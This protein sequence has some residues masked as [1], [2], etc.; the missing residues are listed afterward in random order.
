LTE[1]FRFNRALSRAPSPSVVDGL[2]AVDVGAPDFPGVVREHA[3][4]VRALEDAGV[5]VEVLPALNAFPDS[6]FV[7]DTALVFTGAAILLRPG[8]ASRFGEAAEMAP[9]LERSF[10]RVLRLTQGSVDGGDVLTTSRGVFIGR[11]A[12]TTA[13]GARALG[14]L[15]E[16]IGLHGIVVATP[17]D[18][19]H[20]KSDC[21]LLDDETIL[22]TRR[23]AAAGVFDGFR[24]ALV[25]DGE[26]AAANALR[27]ND[28]VLI[29]DGY[30]R[31]A[32]LLAKS[33]DV[34]ALPTREVAK[35]DAGL[36]CMSLRWRA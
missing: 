3:A 31:T 29:S 32:D 27:V 7:E 26:E 34:V 23:L 24:L 36:S 21:S 2:R 16:A 20:L 28:R 6:V 30:P 9:V 10:P 4:Y 14:G 22:V 17:R 25:P 15:L 11:S 35:I 12:R 18:V 19:L 33:Y 1:A 5:A 13:E 8:A